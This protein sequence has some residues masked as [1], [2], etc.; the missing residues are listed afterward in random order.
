MDVYYYIISNLPAEQQD[1]KDGARIIETYDIIFKPLPKS[2]EGPYESLKELI[3]S[4]KIYSALL[5]NDPK[6]AR[7]IIEDRFIVKK[8]KPIFYPDDG[9]EYSKFIYKIMQ[10]SMSGR[11]DRKVV[12]GIHLFDPNKIKIIEVTKT[13]NN[14]GIWEAY[15]EVYNP[16]SGRWIKKG[17][18]TT[19]FPV[20]WNLQRLIFECRKAFD[21]KVKISGKKYVGNTLSG[22]PV[23]FIFEDGELKSVY[24]NY[25]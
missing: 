15:I 1:L 25:E 11:L 19:F 22:I 18:P 3:T 14:H 12:L 24:P 6:R 16:N 13:K 21:E 20:E 8:A 4:S 17:K 5:V 7:K 23:T 9:S 10:H 2:G